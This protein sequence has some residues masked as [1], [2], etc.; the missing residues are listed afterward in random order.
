MHTIIRVQWNLLIATD[1]S[2]PHSPIASNSPHCCV[3][4]G[5]SDSVI[6]LEGTEGKIISGSVHICF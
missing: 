5:H 3:Y 4:S 2:N 1:W 6:C